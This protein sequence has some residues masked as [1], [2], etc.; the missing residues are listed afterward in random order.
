MKH[1]NEEVRQVLIH[2]K[3]RTA[4]EAMWEDEIMIRSQFPSF[5]LED[6]VNIE[7]GGVDRI[8]VAA[9]DRTPEQLIHHTTGGP[10][11]LYVYSRRKGTK[12]ISG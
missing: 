12:G 1:Q 7:G 2:W 8:H 9:E 5:D 11:I 4:E 3:G 10:R 6:K